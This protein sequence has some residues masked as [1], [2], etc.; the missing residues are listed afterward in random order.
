MS[1]RTRLLRGWAVI[2]GILLVAGIANASGSYV[3]PASQRAGL[4]DYAKYELGKQVSTGRIEL[5]ER[6]EETFDDQSTVLS[7]L[8]SR[9][10][11]GARK[12]LDLPV[13]AGRLS[14]E[15]LD[16]LHYYLKVRYKVR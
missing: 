1:A 14:P 10:P 13:Y 11:R 9:L 2:A 6:S 16:A 7:S 3:R 12:R 15:Q 4:D 8:Q 5:A